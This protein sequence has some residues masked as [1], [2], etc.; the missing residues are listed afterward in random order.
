MARGITAAPPLP[1]GERARRAEGGSVPPDRERPLAVRKGDEPSAR[2]R[3][4]HLRALPLACACRAASAAAPRAAEDE[5]EGVALPGVERAKLPPLLLLWR[6]KSE[7]WRGGSGVEL[8]REG[9]VVVLW[10]EAR[11]GDGGEE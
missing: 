5:G 11:L 9:G 8:W 3:C 1:E 6:M 2:V 7:G 10:R 4:L